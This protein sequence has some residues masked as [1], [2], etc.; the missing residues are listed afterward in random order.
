MLAVDAT[1]ARLESLLSETFLLA[2]YKLD[3]IRALVHDGQLLSRSLK[4]IRNSYIRQALSTHRLNGVDGELIVGLP[5]IPTT[6]NTTT[7]AVMSEAGEPEFTWYVFD[8]IFKNDVPFERRLKYLEAIEHVHSSIVIL[9]Q[10]K[11]ESMEDLKNLE[12]G[13]LEM[14]YEGLI[15]R[16][17]RSPYKFG[18]STLKQGWM[19]KVKRFKDSEAVIIGMDELQR[20]G[21]EA[22][23]D[24][25]GLQKRSSH[26]ANLI[27]GDTL[28]ALI[29]QDIHDGW[30]F[31]IGTGFDTAFRDEVWQSRTNYIGRVVK[32]KYLPYG[33]KD[34]PRHPVFVGFRDK[35]DLD[36]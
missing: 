7:S 35:S 26:I 36:L 25:L 12:Q 1:E 21:N 23:I 8:A 19:L 33:M 28:G 29:V 5:N 6:F 15:V 3:G 16:D 34:V 17:P 10:F 18:R 22:Q 32:Y 14:G 9:P 13:A 30:R 4:P 2:S 24:N 27:P 11:V 31:R 20:N